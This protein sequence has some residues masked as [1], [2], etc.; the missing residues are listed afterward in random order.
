MI[1]PIARVAT[2]L[3][4]LALSVSTASAQMTF[5]I[6]NEGGATA[7]MM[8]G[9]AQAAGLWSARLN[10]PITVNIRINATR[11]TGRGHRTH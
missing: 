10:D 9:F 8:T 5:D 7:Q 6:T 3:A 1:S 11:P 4:T 2:A